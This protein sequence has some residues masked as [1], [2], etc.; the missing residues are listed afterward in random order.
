MPVCLSAITADEQLTKVYLGRPWR[1][2]GYT[3]FMH[4]S[5]PRQIC[6]EGWHH[7]IP[8]RERTARYFEYKNTG[9]GSDVS[10]RVAWAR[11]LSDK[12]AKHLTI[13]EVM[14]QKKE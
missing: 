2:Y 1:D 10:Q 4:C 7:W 5:L 6:P 9:E 11:Q 14:K 13:E 3:L 8:E 12:E